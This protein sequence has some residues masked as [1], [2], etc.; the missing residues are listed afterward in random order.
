MGQEITQVL[1]IT[2]LGLIGWLGVRIFAKLDEIKRC[3]HDKERDLRLE[4]AK[5]WTTVREVQ[6][7]YGRRKRDVQDDGVY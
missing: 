1:L 5:L 4:I 3:I 7:M 6:V 2:L